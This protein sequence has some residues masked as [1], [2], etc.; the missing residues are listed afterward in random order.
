MKREKVGGIILSVLL[1]F[2]TGG[3]YFFGEV[4]WKTALGRPEGISWT[5]FLTAILLAVPLERFGAEL[6][7][8]MPLP[9]QAAICAGAITA[10][11]F[12]AGV[13]LNLRLGL[14][15]WDY[16]HLPGNVLGQICPQ[17]SLLWFA[18]SFVGI[19]LLDWMRYAIEGGERPRYT[20]I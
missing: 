19:V 13:A 17:F 7:W 5:M 3:V 15:I 1:W 10:V 16:S 8:E 11:E 4:V 18:L 9:V 2:W 6:P 14:G 12:F 20:L